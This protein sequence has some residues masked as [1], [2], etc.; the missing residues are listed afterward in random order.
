ML[1]TYLDITVTLD[2]D[3]ITKDTVVSC[4][5]WGIDFSDDGL[6]IRYQGGVTKYCYCKYSIRDN[7]YSYA[8]FKA[9]NYL[10]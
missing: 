2:S 8:L 6:N 5:Q 3:M 1:N 9:C 4:S 7:T 10:R